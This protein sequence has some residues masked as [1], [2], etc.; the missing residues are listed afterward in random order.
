MYSDLPE[1]LLLT[2]QAP[3]SQNGQTQSNNSNCLSVFDH[4]V[5]FVLNGLTHRIIMSEL[6]AKFFDSESSFGC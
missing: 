5:G 1:I 4:F 3:I 6:R 2:L